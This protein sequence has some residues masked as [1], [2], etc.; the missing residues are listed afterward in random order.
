MRTFYIPVDGKGI[1]TAPLGTNGILANSMPGGGNLGRNTFRGPGFE[2]WN[3]SL[4]KAVKIRENTQLQVRAEFM[5]IWNHRNFPNP[6]SV[7]T[8]SSFGQNTA[9]LVGEGVRLILFNAK[10]RF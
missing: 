8:S 2:Q 5:N 3:F 1:V 6:V 9:P 7:M 4:S 10:L